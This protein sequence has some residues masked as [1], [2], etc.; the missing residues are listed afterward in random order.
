M[1]NQWRQFLSARHCM[2]VRPT[3]IPVVCV[4]YNHAASV[5]KNLP[6]N[7]SYTVTCRAPSI[8]QLANI[9]P[10][11]IDRYRLMCHPI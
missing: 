8:H 3:V 6:I 7:Y 4:N 2:T 10:S 9:G 11:Q 1:E 5:A